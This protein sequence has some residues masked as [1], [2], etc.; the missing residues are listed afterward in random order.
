[1]LEKPSG[2]D[3]AIHLFDLDMRIESALYFHANPPFNWLSACKYALEN[4]LPVTLPF[5]WNMTSTFVIA[6][7]Y[8]TSI[9]YDCYFPNRKMWV[10]EGYTIM[11]LT[12]NIFTDISRDI[13]S[14]VNEWIA[15]NPFLPQE[16]KHYMYTHEN[17]I[18]P[19]FATERIEMRLKT[20]LR[21]LES[22]YLR[23]KWK[24]R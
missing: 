6:D 16:E 15:I 3:S 13:D 9:L 8:R 12:E 19:Y 23:R 7:D 24:G 1:M 11:N 21:E 4:H 10:Y 17:I 22:A 5:Y 18:F 14:W 20:A 2:G